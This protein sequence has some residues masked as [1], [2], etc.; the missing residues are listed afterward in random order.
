MFVTTTTLVELVAVLFKSGRGRAISVLSGRVSS[1]DTYDFSVSW[2]GLTSIS[3][4]LTM[5]VGA[6]VVELD[7]TVARIRYEVS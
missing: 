2:P 6:P 1:S 7:A 5:T 3:S 4:L